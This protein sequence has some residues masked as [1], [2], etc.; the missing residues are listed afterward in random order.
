MAAPHVA[1]AM[2]LLRAARPGWSVEELKAAAM[3]SAGHDLRKTTGGAE[4]MSPVRQGAGRIDVPAA[5]DAAVIAYDD[6]ADGE[7]GVSFG[8]V[9]VP[10]TVVRERTVR[11]ADKGGAGGTFGVGYIPATEVLGVS[12]SFPD[13]ASVRV[14][15]GGTSSIRVRLTAVAAEMDGTPDPW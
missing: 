1:G 10:G 5:L 4:R 12:Y 9:Q 2:A 3:N 8:A 14:P 11:V 13:G 6:E 15:P 7:V